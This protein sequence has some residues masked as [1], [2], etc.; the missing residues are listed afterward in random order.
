MNLVQNLMVM[1]VDHLTERLV[2]NLC[3]LV[4]FCKNL[5]FYD[6][7]FFQVTFRG[8]RTDVRSQL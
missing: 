2:G 3:L 6:R 7:P 8:V 4:Y 1:D 5:S